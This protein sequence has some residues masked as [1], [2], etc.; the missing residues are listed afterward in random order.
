MAI[1]VTTPDE[2]TVP[3]DTLLLLHVPP[4]DVVDKVMVF[5]MQTGE[6]PVIAPGKLFT[7]TVA[8]TLHPV[9][10]TYVITDVPANIPETIP[11]EPIVATAVVPLIHVPPAVPSANVEEEPGQTFIVPVIVAG[12]GLTVRIVV[13]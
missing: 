8:C 7:V 11:V 13:T 9:G 12:K 5:P 2:L 10:N 4:V 1:P 3:C 6:M